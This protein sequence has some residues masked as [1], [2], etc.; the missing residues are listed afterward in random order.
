MLYKVSD[1]KSNEINIKNCT[2]YYPND[3]MNLD[4]LEFENII[5]DENT[6]ED[7]YEDYIGIK[8]NTV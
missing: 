5:L 4:D 8:Y 3:L 6:Y 1:I 2:N 7:I